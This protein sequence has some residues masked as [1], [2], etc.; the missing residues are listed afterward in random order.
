M[1]EIDLVG[2][3]GIYCGSCRHYLVLKKKKLKERGF[4][5]GCEGCRIRFKKCAFV[6]R[7]CVSLRK[8]E[9]EFCYE[10]SDFPCDNISKLDARHK[11]NYG[12]KP[13]E[14]LRVI[15]NI[16]VK[17]WIEKQEE[18]YSCPECGGDICIHD[19]DCYDCGFNYNLHKG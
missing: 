3:C 15:E 19:E 4:K 5:R 8:K 10:C 16:G 11:S 14:N 1:K 6:R 17:A 9:I 2:P 7:D 12:D 13:I 18:L